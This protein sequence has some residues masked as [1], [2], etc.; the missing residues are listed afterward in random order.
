MMEARIVLG[1]DYF[2]SRGQRAVPFAIDESWSGETMALVVG[3][4]IYPGARDLF[5]GVGRF[6]REWTKAESFPEPRVGVDGM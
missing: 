3:A 4:R 5:T 1:A 6:A 2:N